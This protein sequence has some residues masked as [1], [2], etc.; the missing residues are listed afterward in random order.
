[1]YD[2][3]WERFYFFICNYV[4]T[5]FTVIDKKSLK[6][7]Q[8][9]IRWPIHERKSINSRAFPHLANLTNLGMFG[10]EKFYF[11]S[12]WEYGQK[13]K[14]SIHL[15]SLRNNRNRMPSTEAVDHS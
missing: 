1:M 8:N 15:D 3:L 11:I 13:N 14:L 12:K 6:F 4:S 9:D 7:W 2:V 10:D 5:A